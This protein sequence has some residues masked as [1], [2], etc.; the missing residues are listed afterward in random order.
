MA[1]ESESRNLDKVIVR[2]PDGMRDR[3][4]NSAERHGRSMNAEIVQ[5]LEQ[6][7][8]P[9]P[10]IIEVIDRVHQAINQAEAAQ[11]LPYRKG[12]IAALDKL[13]E[14]L[15]S[16]IEF[17]Q[18]RSSTLSPSFLR[19]QDFT[20]RHERWKR[21]SENGIE[22]SDLAREIDRGLFGKL[23]RN[24]TWTAIDYFKEGRA[25]M[26]YKLLRLNELKF[27]D[28]S[29]AEALIVAHLRKRYEENWGDPDEPYEPWSD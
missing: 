12:L 28:P 11:S 21:A 5:A 14:R 26:A 10:D 15:T 20:S 29:G 13:S 19:M 7:F 25:D 3:I 2:L 24:Y 9:E 16:G 4:K 1:Q 23:D 27:A 8:P 17:N 22:T 18:A 6:V